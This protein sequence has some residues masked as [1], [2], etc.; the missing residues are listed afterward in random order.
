MQILHLTSTDDHINDGAVSIGLRIGHKP[1]L[2][3]RADR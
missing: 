2:A 1:T 3:E